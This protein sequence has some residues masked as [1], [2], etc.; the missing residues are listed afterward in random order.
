MTTPPPPPVAPYPIHPVAQQTGYLRA[1]EIS[2]YVWAGLHF[3]AIAYILIYLIMIGF[4]AIVVPDQGDAPPMQIIFAATAVVLLISLALAIS[5]ATLSF[6]AG[7]AIA[8]RERKPLIYVA[9][10]IACIGFPVGTTLG[11]FTFIVLANPISKQLFE[12]NR[13]AGRLNC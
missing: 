1:L 11:V 8:K 9:A 10:G 13:A 7:R 5:S 4:M 12:A 3:F 6:L 2:F